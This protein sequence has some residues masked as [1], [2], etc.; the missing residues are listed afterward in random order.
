MPSAAGY[1]AAPPFVVVCPDLTTVTSAY[2]Q[3]DT[4]YLGAYTVYDAINAEYYPGGGTPLEVIT[5]GYNALLSLS[6]PAQAAAGVPVY[7][8]AENAYLNGDTS[9]QIAEAT[10]APYVSVYDAYAS[11]Y[12]AYASFLNTY[13]LAVAYELANPTLPNPYSS[14]NAI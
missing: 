5:A 12:D 8:A 14:T 9:L 7:I 4:A 13:N 6:D 10:Y 1:P 2:T 3:A 11:A